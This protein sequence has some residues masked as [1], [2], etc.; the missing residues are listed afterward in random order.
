MGSLKELSK[1]L[2]EGKIAVV[3]TDTI[4][5]IVGLALNASTV[6][7]IRQIKDRSTHKPFIVLVSS[8]KQLASLG[9]LPTYIE[10][11]LKYWPGP[12]SLIFPVANNI[13]H[14]T[15]GLNSLAVRLPKQ[16]DLIELI[17]QTG[18]LVAPSANPEGQ[19]PATNINEAIKYFGDKI[20]YYFDGGVLNRPP[21][22][23][24]DIQTKKRLR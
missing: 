20:D 14:L 1:I 13:E 8:T 9:I 7:R 2:Q 11:T 17:N 15:C 19:E 5:G 3:P 21:S 22:K 24:I 10:Q 16:E 12:N 18:P 4:Y 6:K 23:L